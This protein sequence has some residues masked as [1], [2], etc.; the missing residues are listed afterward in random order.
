MLRDF[1]LPAIRQAGDVGIVCFQQDGAPPHWRLDVRAFLNQEF[2]G[3]WIGRAGPIAWPPRNAV[4]SLFT[5]TI[6]NYEPEYMKMSNC[7]NYF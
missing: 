7:G 3:K 6:P 2:P 1:F 4:D 5:F